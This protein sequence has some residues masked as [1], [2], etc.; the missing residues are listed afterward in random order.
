M[1]YMDE[2]KNLL[3][4]HFQDADVQVGDM[5]GTQDH[6][7]IAIASAA[8]EGKALLQQ[9]RMV[10]D[11]LKEKFEDKLH[12]VPSFPQ[13]GFSANSVA[14]LNTLGKGFK[15]YDI[16]QDMEVRQGLKEYSQWPTFPQLYINGELIGGNDIITELYQNGELKEMVAKLEA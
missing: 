8:F 5:T 3:L 9:H 13:C 2:I 12:A 10:M 7:E 16:L 15:T 1:S 6:L 14:I 11:V 4:E